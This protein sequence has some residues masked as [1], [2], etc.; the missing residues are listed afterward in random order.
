[1]KFTMLLRDRQE[2][3]VDRYSECKENA[4][5]LSARVNNDRPE[6]MPGMSDMGRVLPVRTYPCAGHIRCKW[7]VK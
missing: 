3:L 2:F 6:A 5:Q 7:L 1:M 4:E